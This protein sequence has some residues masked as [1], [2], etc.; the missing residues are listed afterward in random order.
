MIVAA[1][2]GA[3]K[4]LIAEHI[5]ERC[6]AHGRQVIYT[7]PIKALSNQKFRDWSSLF[8][9]RV[10]IVTGDVSIRRDAPLR[11]MTTEIFRNTIFDRPDSLEAV[12][13]VIFDEIHYINDEERGTVW[14]ESILFA[15]QQID[16]LCLSATI[17]NL[18]ELGRWMAYVRNT[19]VAVVS[20][21]ERPVPLENAFFVPHFGVGRP[22]ELTQIRS[23]SPD[24]QRLLL[25]KPDVD[26]V[27]FV[28]NQGQ[29]PCLYFCHSRK[30]CEDLAFGYAERDLISPHPEALSQYDVLCG[31][32]GIAQAKTALLL[33]ESIAYG[34]AY[35][36]A[37]LL[38]PLKHVVERMFASGLIQLIFTTETFAVGLNLS[39]Q[40][41]GQNSRLHE[42]TSVAKLW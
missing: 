5:V 27:E 31:Q 14:E 23:A 4:T 9:S 22:E 24:K 25:S 10:G 42:R 41:L 38:P 15:P 16:F 36:H 17:R 32:Q 8:G 21:T 12:S 29:L 39:V 19:D 20:E 18:K 13:Y 30:R 28:R 11:I 26:V 2:T 1:P 33:R 37:G 40:Y 6:L 3:G 35:H 34:I 7:A